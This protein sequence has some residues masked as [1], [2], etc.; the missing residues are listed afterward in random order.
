M[1]VSGIA[2]QRSKVTRVS[3]PA[4]GAISRRVAPRVA[5]STVKS[6]LAAL[7]VLT[8]S[9]LCSIDSVAWSARARRRKTLP[10]G[11]YDAVLLCEAC[12]LT[13]LGPVNSL[14]RWRYR[15]ARRQR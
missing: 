1:T 7:D 3:M 13:Q 4:A 8:H 9:C 15:R 12:R 2:T 14:L 5:G 11:S 10:T 6:V